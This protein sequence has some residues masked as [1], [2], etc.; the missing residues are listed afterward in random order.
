[1]DRL[2]RRV[3]I[4]QRRH[5]ATALERLFKFTARREFANGQGFWVAPHFWFIAGLTRDAQEEEIDLADSPMLSGTVG[6]AFYRVM[7]RN[8][9]H[10]MF[11]VLR[12]LQIDLIFVED[13]VRYRRF[14]KVL[15]RLFDLYDK[16]GDRRRAGNAHFAGLPGTKVVIHDFQLDEPFKSETYPEPKYDY[17]GRAHLACVSRSSRRRRV[18]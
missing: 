6:P 1:M 11:Q 7:P 2:T 9:R 15:R 16:H 18:D 3:E 17:L 14:S 4:Q 13:G 10:H 5:V 8:A 12:A